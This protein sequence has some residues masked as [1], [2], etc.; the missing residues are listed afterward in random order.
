MAICGILVD[1]FAMGGALLRPV[2]SGVLICSCCHALRR[3][4]CLWKKKP[5]SPN[6]PAE[7]TYAQNIGTY[8]SL[9]VE[10]VKSKKWTAW[11][12]LGKSSVLEA[13]GQASTTDYS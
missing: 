13:W 5:G 4:A 6:C 8:D 9:F 3:K 2:F 11:L 10:R 1:P 12:G 7:H